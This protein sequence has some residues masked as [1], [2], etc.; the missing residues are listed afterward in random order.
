MQGRLVSNDVSFWPKKETKLKTDGK[1]YK[2]LTPPQSKYRRLAQFDR[3][4]QLRRREKSGGEQGP[5]RSG[6]LLA[7]DLDTLRT[8]FV[9]M[10]WIFTQA[11]Q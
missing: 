4:L 7:A 10:L 1:F 11:E 3:V 8:S 2:K 6:D 9:W 5:E